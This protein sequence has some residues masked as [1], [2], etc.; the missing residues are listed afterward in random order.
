LPDY[1]D[2]DEIAPMCTEDEL[3]LSADTAEALGDSFNGRSVIEGYSR[4]KGKCRS[5]HR[6]RLKNASL[7]GRCRRTKIQHL[8]A[9]QRIY[10]S[11]PDVGPLE[12]Q[13]LLDAFDSGWIAPAGPDLDRFEAMLAERAG[14]DHCVA[15]SSGTAAIHLA[16]LHHGVGPGDEVVVSTFTFAA[17]ANA[18]M[19]TGAKPIF[20]DSALKTWNMDPELLR[21][22]L[23]RKAIQNRLPK[24]VLVV[25]LYGHCASYDEIVP[26]CAEYGVP[27]IEDAAEAL[28]GSFNGQ[29]AG[30]FG[31]AGILSF[32]GNKIITTSGGGALCSNNKALI[33]RARYLSTQARQPFPH[34]EHTD[35]GYNYR[36]SNLLAAMGC[37]QLDGLPTKIGRRHE[38]RN[39]YQTQFKDHPGV[40]FNPIADGHTSN[41]W[42]TCM[43]LDSKETPATPEAVRLALEAENI[44]SRPLWK[45]MHLQPVFKNC[46]AELNGVSDSLF[47]QGLCLPSGS[48]MTDQSLNN[49]LRELS[50]TIQ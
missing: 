7:A 42:L 43:V 24:A 30:S 14:T 32:N 18:V 44:E 12:R 15:L 47:A 31:E 2:Y 35:I 40:T 38:I 28:G 33:D 39:A 3:T 29:K 26:I 1:A 4:F 23:A 17:T 49:V 36:L 20:V 27:L 21:A 37:A 10:L 46:E 34:Y 6:K 45:P 16:L 50:K 11:P 19:Y 8:M 9:S 13:M 48:G 25:D 5:L 22:L 41:A